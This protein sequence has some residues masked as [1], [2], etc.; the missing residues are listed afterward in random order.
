MIS[1]SKSNALSSVGSA[2]SPQRYDM[3]S[4][5]FDLNNHRGA[6]FGVSRDKYDSV[7][8]PENP[9]HGKDVPGPGSYRANHSIV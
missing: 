9:Q 1:K 3:K 8:I 6:P 7:Y 4:P 5:C 2:P